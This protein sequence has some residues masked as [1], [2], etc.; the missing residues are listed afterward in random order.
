M[1][2]NELHEKWPVLKEKIIQLHP[3][4]TREELI[5]EIGKEEDLL[6]KLQ[7]KTGKTDKEI[8]NWLALLG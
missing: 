1:D 7:K 2:N 4:L 5:L 8:R 3:E 6:L